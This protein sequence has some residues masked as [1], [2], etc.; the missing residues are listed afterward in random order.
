MRLAMIGLGRMGRNMVRRLMSAGHEV[1]VYSA[2]AKT[3]ESFAKDTGA[4]A[5][6]SLDELVSK[7]K[8]PPRNQAARTHYGRICGYDDCVVALPK[9][10]R[11]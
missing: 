6:S 1:I 9:Y 7:L 8:P 3:S 4:T 5:A 2:T 11:T 10:Q